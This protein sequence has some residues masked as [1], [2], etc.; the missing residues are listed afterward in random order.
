MNGNGSDLK[1]FPSKAVD[2]AL[3]ASVILVQRLKL[4]RLFYGPIKL[5]HVGIYGWI[6]YDLEVCGP[7]MYFDLPLEPN[8]KGKLAVNFQ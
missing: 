2:L 3:F 7:T 8:T 1:K 6:Y 4:W 5:H